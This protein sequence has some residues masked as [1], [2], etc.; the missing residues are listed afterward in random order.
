MWT[1]I[2]LGIP[3]RTSFSL[4][5]FTS[6]RFFSQRKEPHYPKNRIRSVLTPGLYAKRGEKSYDVSYL[7]YAPFAASEMK[8]DAQYQIQIFAH[9]R[10][11]TS[12]TIHVLGEYTPMGPLVT[13]HPSKQTY[14]IPLDSEYAIHA[15]LNHL[16]DLPSQQPVACELYLHAPMSRSSRQVDLRD[17]DFLEHCYNWGIRHYLQSHYSQHADVHLRY[18]NTMRWL[19]Y[20]WL[21]VLHDHHSYSEGISHAL[22]LRSHVMDLDQHDPITQPIPVVTDEYELTGYRNLFYTQKNTC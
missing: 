16:V 9:S 19:N 8:C 5:L 7:Y 14:A 17:V 3:L 6:K 22:A 10:T 15:D 20:T 2:Q 1:S 18:D 12:P 13:S 4:S 11:H 21:A